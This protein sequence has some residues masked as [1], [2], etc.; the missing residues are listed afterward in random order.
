MVPQPVQQQQP[1]TYQQP[2][3]YQQ[4]I[5]P[6]PVVIQQT[7]VT[8]GSSI[9]AFILGLLLPIIFTFLFWLSWHDQ[10]P[11]KT[12]SLLFGALA[13]FL[14]FNLPGILFLIWANS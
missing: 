1:P 4:P 6:Q 2:P 11:L 10:Q 14:F 7:I 8:D 3:L 9:G 5:P 13:H 12:R